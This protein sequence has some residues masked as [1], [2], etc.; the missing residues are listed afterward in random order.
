MLVCVCVC[1][2]V[3]V[4]GGGGSMNPFPPD[5]ELLQRFSVRHLENAEGMEPG[6]MWYAK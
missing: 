6:R 3:S 1:L 2:C 5:C 4:D